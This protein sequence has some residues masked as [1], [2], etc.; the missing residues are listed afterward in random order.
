MVASEVYKIAEEFLS[1]EEFN[2]L[3][4]MFRE[5]SNTNKNI[6]LPKKKNALPD[7]TN[8]DALR[9]LLD[10]HINKKII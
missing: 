1:K 7:Y 9:F 8:K 4:D 2:K 10:N 3:S 5:N 6:K